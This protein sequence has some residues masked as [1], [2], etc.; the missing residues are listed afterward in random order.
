MPKGW[1]VLW[2]PECFVSVSWTEEDMQS[3][4]IFDE[5]L[6]AQVWASLNI[7]HTHPEGY[8]AECE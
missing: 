3:F 2:C 6:E 5:W 1:F 8:E 7:E 4:L